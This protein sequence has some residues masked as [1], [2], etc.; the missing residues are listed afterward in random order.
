[1]AR[2]VDLLPTVLDLMGD[3]APHDV[4]GTSLVPAFS[5]KEVATGYSY[6]ETLYPKINHG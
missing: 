5:G 6:A 3:K 2:T 1:M 4:Q